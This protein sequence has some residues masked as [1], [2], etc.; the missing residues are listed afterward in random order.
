[1][2]DMGYSIGIE[3]IVPEV[4]SALMISLAKVFKIRD[5]DLKNPQ[6]QHWE[7]ALRIFDVIL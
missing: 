6:T 7:Q 4:V 3:A 5:E 2:L 1:M